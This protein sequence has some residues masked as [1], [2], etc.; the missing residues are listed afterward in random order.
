MPDRTDKEKPERPGA[1]REPLLPDVPPVDLQTAVS[2]LVASLLGARA[3]LDMETARMARLYQEDEILRQFQPPAFS[4]GEVTL[5]LPFAAVEVKPVQA[6]TRGALTTAEVPPMQV[7]V[8]AEYLSAL[9]PHAVAVV[10]LKL[11]QEQLSVL[12][13]QEP[14]G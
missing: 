6:A 13:N 1:P 10:E 12:L 8:N 14:Q 5:R 4:M 9:A 11:T 7:Q 2:S 3:A